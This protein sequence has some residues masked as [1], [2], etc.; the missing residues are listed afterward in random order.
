MLTRLVRGTPLAPLLQKVLGH[1]KHARIYRDWVR[2]GRPVPPPEW[3]KRR[4][5]RE[6]VRE[7]RKSVFVETG[8]YCGDTLAYLLNEFRA[9]HS[10][11]LDDRMYQAAVERFRGFPHVRLYH[12]DSGVLLKQIVAELTEPAFFWLDAHYSGGKTAKGPLETPIMQELE[13]V[14]KG[15]AFE[16][17]VL[18]DDARLFVGSRDYPP[19]RVLESF[20]AECR[21]GSRFAV[22]DDIVRI[23]LARGT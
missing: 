15:S 10:V 3:V 17:A 23:F 7:Q 16:H 18:I 9:L 4:F 19:L 2:Q 11:E 22:Q 21:P 6:I 8:T 12:G 20:V 1:R 5:L 13:T 14:M